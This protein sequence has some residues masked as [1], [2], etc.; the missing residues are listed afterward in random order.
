MPI[1]YGSTRVNDVFYGNKRVLQIYHGS[2]LVYNAEIGLPKGYV[3]L[4]YIEATGTQYINTGIY[5]KGDNW[6]FK[7]EYEST[8][9]IINKCLTGIQNGNSL[10]VLYNGSLYCQPTSTSSSKRVTTN[11]WTN[12]HHIIDIKTNGG[13][14]ESK[15]DSTITAYELGTTTS[16]NDELFNIYPVCVLAYWYTN[17]MCTDVRKLAAKLYNY[18]IYNNDK[19]VCNLVPAMK[20]SDG[21]VGMYDLHR[22]KFLTNAGTGDFIAGPIVKNLPSRYIEVDYLQGDG[23]SYINTGLILNQ[24]QEIYMKIQCVANTPAMSI[25]GSRESASKNNIALLLGSSQNLLVDFNNSDY[26]TYRISTS[27]VI[28]TEYNIILSKSL[29]QINNVSSSDLCEDTILSPSTAYL[30]AISGS[31]ASNNLF[32]GKIYNCIIKENNSYLQYLVPV[33]DIVENEYCMYDLVTRTAFRNVGTG[34]FTGGEIYPNYIGLNNVES[35]GEK[36]MNTGIIPNQDY[37]MELEYE[38]T[39]LNTQVFAGTRNVNPDNNS[40]HIN[41]GSSSQQMYAFDGVSATTGVAASLYKHKF[42][43]TKNKATYD[44]VD[45]TFSSSNFQSTTPIFLFGCSSNNMLILSSKAKIY[46][47]KIWNGKTLVADYLPV[48][49]KSTNE[50]GFI[51]KVDQ[52]FITWGAEIPTIP[53]EYLLQDYITFN[54]SSNYV[55]SGIVPKNISNL[56]INIRAKCD[57]INPSFQTIHGLMNTATITTPRMGLHIYN[58]YYM[59]GINNTTNGGTHSKDTNWHDFK[60]TTNSASTLETLYIDDVLDKNSTASTGGFSEN[61]LSLYIG[62]RHQHDNTVNYFTGKIA[63]YS[64]KQ[65]GTMIKDLYPVKRFSDLTYGFFDVINKEFLPLH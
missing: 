23:N 6:R 31:P 65:N 1:N 46:H 57:N 39:T 12:G 51:N 13:Y 54:G 15:L 5:L 64:Y 48:T 24:N 50:E 43:L 10:F 41:I 47:C 52:S 17:D 56:E 42:Y 49:K 44:E 30:F 33:F 38:P 45:Y 29:R 63:H 59:I 21:T 53:S 35:T 22:R 26:T 14:V 55:D 27:A 3:E 16:F 37:S 25:F 2:N 11:I 19:T 7:V 58:N 62:A 20:I 28:G 8:G 9:S 61:D 36:Y 60:L 40:F 18:R 32:T 4:E 34:A